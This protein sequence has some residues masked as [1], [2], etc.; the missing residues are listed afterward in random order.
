M[1]YNSQGN[2]T[3]IILTFIT[4]TSDMMKTILLKIL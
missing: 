1:T 3:I 2:K 4:I